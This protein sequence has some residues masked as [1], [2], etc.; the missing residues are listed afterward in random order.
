MW[1]ALL[2][3]LHLLYV[4]TRVGAKSSK[5]LTNLSACP[6]HGLQELH[7][8]IAGL[9]APSLGSRPTPTS[10][11]HQQPFTVRPPANGPPVPSPHAA[12][13]V[14][15]LREPG[16]VPAA[17]MAAVCSLSRLQGVA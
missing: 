17:V 8:L 4:N 7:L 1:C 3:L 10:P 12:S 5:H 16:D 13:G 14:T 6:L 2:L 15:F 11:L 9:V